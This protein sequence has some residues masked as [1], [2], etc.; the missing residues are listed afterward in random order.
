MIE[1]GVQGAESCHS[2]DKCERTGETVSVSGCNLSTQLWHSLAYHGQ[3]IE[4]GSG[5]RGR[6]QRCLGKRVE[7]FLPTFYAQLISMI[8]KEAF[9]SV[10]IR[11]KMRILV[12]ASKSLIMEDGFLF[13]SM[14]YSSSLPPTFA[15]P[16]FNILFLI[17]LVLSC[18][19]VF[20]FHLISK[21]GLMSW[22]R[23]RIQRDTFSFSSSSSTHPPL[24]LFHCALNQV[25]A[26]YFL[27]HKIKSFMNWKRRER[28]SD[29]SERC[30]N[31]SWCNW[32][33]RV[34]KWRGVARNNME[35]NKLM[36]SDLCWFVQQIRHP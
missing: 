10:G 32:V 8:W 36:V 12:S 19:F 25:S 17:Q 27:D 31:G 20:P 22:K 14:L 24:P 34:G 1:D 4:W 18:S 35:C 30:E 15:L 2:Q 13:L 21:S 9:C 11:V 7:I 33:G 29:P 28:L 6:Q 3:G 23:E 16:S 5:V 26:P